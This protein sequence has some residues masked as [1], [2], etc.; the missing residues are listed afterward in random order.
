MA[1]KQACKKQSLRFYA[2]LGIVPG[3]PG[4]A[5]ESMRRDPW[6]TEGIVAEEW[7][8]AAAESAATFRVYPPS[9]V[10]QVA[11]VGYQIEGDGQRA[12]QV[13]TLTGTLN[14]H[15][16][17]DQEAWRAAVLDVVQR[18]GDRFGQETVQVNFEEVEVVYYQRHPA[19]VTV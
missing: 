5:G 4:G 8:E 10:V 3:Y 6:W 9:V 14:P 1:Y 17:D 18:L 16:G 13:V 19:A 7:N 2:A 11:T 12:E 15:W